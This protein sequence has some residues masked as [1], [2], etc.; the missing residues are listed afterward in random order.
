MNKHINYN[1]V[2]PLFMALLLG[3]LA[4]GCGGG[5]GGRDPILGTGGAQAIVIVP[6]NAILPG[7]P[8]RS[9]GPPFPR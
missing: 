3:A 1:G 6:T 2:R 7:A 8:V 4:A 5:G 9:R